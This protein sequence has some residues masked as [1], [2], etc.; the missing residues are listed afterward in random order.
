MDR[1]VLG[2][3]PTRRS[4]FSA[5]DA[6][7][8]RKIITEKLEELD[9]EFVDIDDINE[10][11]LLYDEDDRLRVLKKFQDAGVDGLFLPHC[12]FGTEFICARL[13]KDLGK[14]VLLWGPLDERPEA[15]G[16]RLRDTQ[17]GLF[18][19]GKVLRRFEVPFT[20]MTNCRVDDPVFEHGLRDFIA[21]CNVVKKFHSARILQIGPRPYEFYSTMCNEGELLERFGVE[22]VPVPLPELT[23]GVKAAL[24]EDKGNGT[25]DVEKQLD[26]IDEHFEKNCTDE[27][28]RTITAMAVTMRRML[29][30]YHCTAG[31]I[32][33]WNELQH[34]LHVMPCAANSILNEEGTP[35][36][37]ETDVHGAITSLMIEAADMGRK[38]SFFADWTIRHPDDP[39]GELLQH[40]GPWP[41]SVAMKKPTITTPLAF[42]HNGTLTAEAKHGEVTLCRFDGDN[43]KYSLLLGT[44]EGIDGPKGMGTYLWVRVKNIKRLEAKIVEG[45]YIHHC[46]GIHDDVVPVLYEACKYLGIQP[47]LYDPI[48]EDVKAY[49]RGE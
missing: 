12:N 18:A 11:G 22:C 44:A 35:I 23:R 28:V 9:V 21:V 36:T 49:L 20:Y 24:A 42:D 10:E 17:C 25:S 34:E 39:N 47:D 32:Q 43:G 3:A 2:Y 14:P 30:K 26:W 37:C 6:R 8:Y 48:E 33:C 27:Q 16:V 15:N 7:K 19:T 4:I 41:C 31:C 46:T 13:A 45:P 38:R 40:C 1:I 5:P 29:K